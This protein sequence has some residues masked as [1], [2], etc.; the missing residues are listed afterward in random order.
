VMSLIVVDADIMRAAGLSEKPTATH[1]RMILESIQH[2]GHSIVIAKPLNDEYKRHQSQ[3]A[4]RWKSQMVSNKRVKFT[5]YEDNP[6]LRK[7]LIQSLP[8]DNVAAE[9]AVEKDAHLL[10]IAL[11]H[12]Q[13]IVS[14]DKK[15]KKYFQ[16]SCVVKGDHRLLLWAD[17]TEKPLEVIEWIGNG[18]ADQNHWRLCPAP[19]KPAHKKPKK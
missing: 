2:R 16:H 11:Q 17:A 15:A 4:E 10:E 3:F 6:A 14:K 18:C 9:A 8:A 13:R 12:G 1:A 5:Q 7:L 19:K